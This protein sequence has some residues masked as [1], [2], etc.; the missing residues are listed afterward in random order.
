MS[1]LDELLVVVAFVILLVELGSLRMVR[2]LRNKLGDGD[3]SY[4]LKIV[5]RFGWVVAFAQ[6]LTLVNAS[7]R[8][9]DYIGT[10]DVRL[11]IFFATE[12][13]LGA[14]FLWTVWEVKH[15][16]VSEKDI[17]TRDTTS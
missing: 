1:P 11:V 12:V 3:G 8:R 13:I 16:P 2:N 14:A 6:T 4:L 15:C 5:Y 10:S 7:L 17:S 9:E